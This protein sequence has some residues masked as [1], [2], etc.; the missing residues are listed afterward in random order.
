MNGSSPV[1]ALGAYGRGIDTLPPLER[2]VLLYD[3]A[4]RFLEEAKRAAEAGE[5]ERRFRASER[6]REIVRTLD[7]AL[8]RER[9]GEIAA[10]LARLYGYVEHRLT[11]LNIRNDPAIA[12][13]LSELLRTLRE[14]WARIA[15]P[16]AAAPSRAAAPTGVRLSA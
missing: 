5:I 12:E 15:R 4:L 9:G 3:A 13:E 6:V 1:R 10:R 8:D 7:S 2:V 11:A 16:A 14:A